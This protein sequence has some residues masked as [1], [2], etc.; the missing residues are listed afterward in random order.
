MGAS[1]GSSN[2]HQGNLDTYQQ[3]IK[4]LDDVRNSPGKDDIITCADLSR[5]GY[6]AM[7]A[8]KGVYSLKI[9]AKLDA[10]YA[11]LALDPVAE[12]IGVLSNPSLAHRQCIQ[13]INEVQKIPGR[14]KIVTC[15]GL[16]YA[17]H[18]EVWKMPNV[19]SLRS[20]EKI[21]A[22]FAYTAQ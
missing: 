5:E 9:D 20:N 13:K 17:D 14:N 15:D 8:I 3:C 2:A 16:S 18:S 6:A 4:K 11:V 7:L 1:F 12:E 22:T 21:N 10:T 19:H